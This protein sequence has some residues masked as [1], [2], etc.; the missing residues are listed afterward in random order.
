MP[1]DTGL[2]LARPIELDRL[3]SEAAQQIRRVL[4]CEAIAIALVDERS[5]EL[6]A[7]LNT[8]FDEADPALEARL[9]PR[10]SDVVTRGT[11]RLDVTP[12]GP[13]L[14]VPIPGDA[15]TLG[16]VSARYDSSD[17]PPSPDAAEHALASVAAQIGVAVERARSARRHEL[18]TAADTAARVAAGIANELR[19]PLFGIASA[20]QL[21]RF[22]AREDPV[23]E[24]NVGRIL[25][26]VERLNGMAAEL[27]EY[28]NPAPLHL[29]PTDPDRVWDEVLDGNRGLLES[30]SLHVERTRV[31]PAVK[32]RADV[33]Q[34]AQ[35]FANILRPAAE[36][37]PPTSEIT[38]KSA[39][40]GTMWRCTLHDSGP[41]I[42]RDALPHLF[43]L[44][45]PARPGGTGIALALAQRIIQEHHGTIAIESAEERG[46]TATVLLPIRE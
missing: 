41:P 20:A 45:T 15:T 7:K 40:V 11:S 9:R 35:A 14:T 29:A 43:D 2:A 31:K 21:L 6:K 22:R 46:T 16:A 28:G 33:T 37:A 32:V 26:E 27:L 8:G 12:G 3:W 10:W 42:P 25:H 39:I 23:V 38:L 17:E 44:F 4:P 18:R 19:N 1:V 13:E 5:G 34:L 30:R 36:S 24:R